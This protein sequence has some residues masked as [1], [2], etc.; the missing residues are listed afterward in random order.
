MIY[1]GQTELAQFVANNLKIE[2]MAIT[3]SEKKPFGII[4]EDFVLKCPLLSLQFQEQ[5]YQEAKGKT[6]KQLYAIEVTIVSYFNLL[7]TYT[8][9]YENNQKLTTQY[10]PKINPYKIIFNEVRFIKSEIMKYFPEIHLNQT[11]QENITQ[12]KKI[13]HPKH[14]PN[15]WN[16]KCYKLFKYLFDNYYTGTKRQ[17][18]NIWFY[19]KEIDQVKY[20]LKATKN[21]YKDFIKQEYKIEIKNFDK[22]TI[23]YEDTEKKTLIE[24]RINFDS[25]MK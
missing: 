24:H 25:N 18:T 16:K 6:R 8:K 12:K 23:K 9:W 15:L 14:D 7:E 5:L 11:T 20:N 19:L 22:A 17:L 2:F 10:F 21:K 3:A 13:P 1:I 4:L